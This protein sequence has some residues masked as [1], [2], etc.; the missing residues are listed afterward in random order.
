MELSTSVCQSMPRGL[1]PKPSIFLL[2]IET[3][4]LCPVQDRI[5]EIAIGTY[6]PQSTQSNMRVFESIVRTEQEVSQEAF[7]LHGISR[8]MT[9]PFPQFS[10]VWEQVLLF[11]SSNTT[12]GET[13]LVIAHNAKFDFSFMQ[14][15]L[16]R[17]NT[18]FPSWQIYCTFVIYRTFWPKQKASL[19]VLAG[20]RQQNP[21][22]ALGKPHRACTDILLLAAL[23]DNLQQDLLC[24]NGNFFFVLT[25]YSYPF[26]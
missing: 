21:V 16:L 9:E 8:Q 13:P 15:A 5:I 20:R 2:D 11:V 24:I 23:L 4:G 25:T 18:R 10:S 12:E 17:S 22:A 19:S 6:C 7:A 26:A 14:N 3:T 1:Q